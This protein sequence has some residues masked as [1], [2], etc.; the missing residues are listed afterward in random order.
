MN[1]KFHSVFFHTEGRHFAREFSVCG[2]SK[3]M[4]FRTEVLS[5]AGMG[6][7][8]AGLGESPPGHWP[9]AQKVAASTPVSF[10]AVLFLFNPSC[11]AARICPRSWGLDIEEEEPGYGPP[12]S[13]HLQLSPRCRAAGCRRC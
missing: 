1:L 10:T 8:W 7:G 3:Y 13:D 4:L 9:Q 5:S 2:V 12:L 11:S 6:Q